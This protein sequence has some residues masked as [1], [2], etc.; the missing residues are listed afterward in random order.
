MCGEKGRL[1]RIGLGVPETVWGVLEKEFRI[2]FRGLFSMVACVV[3]KAA[4]G[5]EEE[6]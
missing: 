4:E 2:R 1:G 5:E 3:A 6:G